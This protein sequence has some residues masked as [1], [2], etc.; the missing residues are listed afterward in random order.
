[1]FKINQIKFSCNKIIFKLGE[2]AVAWMI[3]SH[4]QLKE[5]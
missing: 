3:L 5:L 1:M 2:K 4:T